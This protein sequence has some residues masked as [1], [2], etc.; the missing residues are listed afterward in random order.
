MAMDGNTTLKPKTLGAGG[1]QSAAPEDRRRSQRVMIRTPVTLLLAN[2]AM[3]EAYTVEVNVHGA[4]LLCPRALAAETKFEL[5]NMRTQ[6]K[7][8]CRVVRRPIESAGGYLVPVE[9]AAAAA[10]FWGISFPP[11]NWKPSE[12]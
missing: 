2:T 8:L 11:A 3:I 4:M 9:F 6:E 1:A 12:D 5:Q 7:Q 10:H